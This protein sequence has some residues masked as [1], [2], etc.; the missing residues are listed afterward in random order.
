MNRCQCFTSVKSSS[1]I[2]LQVVMGNADSH[3]SF[4]SPAKPSGSFRFSSRRDEV[5]SAHSWWRSGQGSGQGSCRSRG[6]SYLNHPAAGSPYTSWRY[7]QAPKAAAGGPRLKAGSPQTFCRQEQSQFG[8]SNRI[9]G[10]RASLESGGSPKVLLS[11]DGSMRVEFS[12]ARVVPMEPQ[13]LNGLSSM[14]ATA[15]VAAGPEASLRTSNGSSLSS[16]SSWYDS[17]WGNGELTDNVFVYGQNADNSSGYTTATSS[18]GYN[19]FFSAQG[20]DIS[21]GFSSTLLFPA[22]EVNMFAAATGYNICSSGRTEDSGIG[23]SVI[24]QPDLRD[25]SPIAPA[26]A[27][28]SHNTLPAFPT[29]TDTNLQQLGA[30]ASSAAL[31]DDVIQNEEGPVQDMEEAYTS[32]TLP[33]QKVEPISAASARN[34]RK[35]FLKSRI[36]RLSDWTGSLSRKKRRIQ[37]RSSNP[38]G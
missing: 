35:D 26:S 21:P 29:D 8:G 4:V 1:F 15:T 33:C 27:Y 32:C 20:E 13:S 12:K 6:R 3:S 11:K 22:A 9:C 18:S 19:T 37:V 24:L 16:N 38:A 30:A 34:N 28:S 7:E 2:V 31:L 25:F 14:T 36:R 5:T 23:D 17:P 10:E